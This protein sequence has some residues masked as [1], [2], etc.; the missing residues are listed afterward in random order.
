MLTEV[1]LNLSQA[2]FDRLKKAQMSGAAINMKLS[3]DQLKNGG[4]ALKL[5]K[6]TANKIDK[7]LKFD[8]G[9]VLRVNP[10]QMRIIEG[11]AITAATT[12]ASLGMANDF[13]NDYPAVKNLLAG[14]GEDI[15]YLF[16][17]P[18]AISYKFIV[19][20]KIPNLNKRY[21][22]IG[23][24]IETTKKNKTLLGENQNVMKRAND[25]RV[26]NLENLQGKVG[27]H[28]QTLIER[29]PH[30][31]KM[32]EERNETLK[33]RQADQLKKQIEATEKQLE[34]LKK[35]KTGTGLQVGNALQVGNGLQ[36]DGNGIIIDTIKARI[37][38][39]VDKEKKKAK[40]EINKKK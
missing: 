8:K 18:L 7:S 29:I 16:E 19:S 26:I 32:A 9:M 2:Q 17:N 31:R 36:V 37:A 4:I 3:K 20:V 21:R 24:D 40:A 25:R 28:I 22:D 1:K 15:K 23:I 35:K 13:L 34:S 12:I 6:A 27:S 38:P 5:P 11:G 10:K 14:M 39:L 33:A 30:I